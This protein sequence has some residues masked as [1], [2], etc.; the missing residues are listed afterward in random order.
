MKKMN[1]A[2]ASGRRGRKK[3]G[4]SMSENHPG[5]EKR[6]RLAAPSFIALGGGH[7]AGFSG[8]YLLLHTRGTRTMTHLLFRAKRR[9]GEGSTTSN[10]KGFEVGPCLIS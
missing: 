9:G 4:T 7:G 10:E 2:R 5:E 8:S 6:K 3:K 1:F